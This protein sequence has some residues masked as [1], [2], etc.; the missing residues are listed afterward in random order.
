MHVS[1]EHETTPPTAALQFRG[2]AAAGYDATVG[3]MTRWIVPALLRAARLA[4]GMRVLDIATD[5]GLAAE[6]AA[7]RGRAILATSRPPTSRPPCSTGRGNA[8][9]LC[10]D[11]DADGAG[12]GDALARVAASQVRRGGSTSRTSSRVFH[13]GSGGS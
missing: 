12:S 7:V 9:A 2:T 4:P 10:H 8:S 11:F 3:E 5:T 6:A 1:L 13:S